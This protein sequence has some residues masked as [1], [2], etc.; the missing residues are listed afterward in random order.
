MTPTEFRTRFPEFRTATDAMLQPILAEAT[1][2]VAPE[3]F[4]ALTESAIGYLAADALAGSPFGTTQR[5]EDDK[6]ETIYLR[7]YRALLKQKAIRM[8]WT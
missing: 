4:G 6:A 3:T 8:T 5:L 2:R 7:Q 1:L